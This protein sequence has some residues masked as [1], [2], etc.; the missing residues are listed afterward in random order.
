MA[1][2]DRLAEAACLAQVL[3]SPT[4]VRLIK[5]V[6]AEEL[7]VCEL[8]F[9]LG[10]SQ[11]AVSQHL[12]KLRAAGMVSERREGTLA[13]YRA[14]DISDRVGASVLEVLLADPRTMPE[15]ESS[16]AQLGEA[17]QRRLA[18]KECDGGERDEHA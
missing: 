10:V 2:S 11:P 7:C 17:R 18:A 9:L 16:L 4:R 1:E 15:M 8:A 12:A 13:L 3:S 5:L 14:A 6:Q